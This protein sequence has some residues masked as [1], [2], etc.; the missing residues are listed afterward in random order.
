MERSSKGPRKANKSAPRTPHEASFTHRRQGGAPRPPRQTKPTPNAPA[1]VLP[2]DLVAPLEKMIATAKGH[3]DDA[4]KVDPA[5]GYARRSYSRNAGFA[6]L[7]RVRTAPSPFAGP[8]VAKLMVES[9]KVRAQLAALHSAHEVPPPPPQ[10]TKRARAWVAQLRALAAKIPA[11]SL[12]NDTESD[13][14]IALHD[15]LNGMLWSLNDADRCTAAGVP[16]GLRGGACGVEVRAM[17][18]SQA[19]AA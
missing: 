8:D 15:A 1:P 12:G 9:E 19:G 17:T 13:I 2:N 3:A 5:W 18:P 14:L 4:A 7:T 11:R 10:R 6:V 16:T